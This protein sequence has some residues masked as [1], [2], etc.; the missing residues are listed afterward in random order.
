MARNTVNHKII[1]TG[2]DLGKVFVLTEMDAS[3]A[4]A[5]ALRALLAL[6]TNG[7]DMPPGFENTGM[8]GVAQMGL[9]AL[10]GLRW[11]VAAPLLE[12]MW[13]CVQI[14]PDPSKPHVVRNLIESDIEEV[15]TRVKLRSEVWELHT[16][17][18]IAG[19][20]S[21]SAASPAVAAPAGRKNSRNT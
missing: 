11:E 15:M 8:A 9:K 13:S 14:M 1:D 10:A 17:F 4:E 18:S 16:G 20:L 5:W 2:R 6:M 7:V 21:K 12:E 19:A 3:R